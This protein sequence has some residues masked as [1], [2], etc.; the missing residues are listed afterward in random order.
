M[1]KSLLSLLAAPG[2]CP[3]GWSCIKYSDCSEFSSYVERGG[4]FADLRCSSDQLSKVCCDPQGEWKGFGTNL[5]GG[6][7]NEIIRGDLVFFRL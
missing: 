7:D 6:R 3:S 5:T 1:S 4:L 2:P